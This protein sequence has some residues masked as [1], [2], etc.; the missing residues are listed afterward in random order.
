MSKEIQ[1]EMEGALLDMVEEQKKMIDPNRKDDDSE[2]SSEQSSE[3]EGSQANEF[4]FISA[5]DVGSHFIDIN[6]TELTFT[7]FEGNLIAQ[8]TISNPCKKCP[9]AFFVYTSSPIPIKIVPCSGFIPATF[10]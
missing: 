5:I 10:Q 3:E 6:T 9:I 1:D 4:T 2:N 7:E 8:F